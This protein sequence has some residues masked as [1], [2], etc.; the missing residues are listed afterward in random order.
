[1]DEWRNVA[2]EERA[3]ALQELQEMR[4]DR[5]FFLSGLSEEKYIYI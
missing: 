2:G 4:M 5:T 1:M 3:A